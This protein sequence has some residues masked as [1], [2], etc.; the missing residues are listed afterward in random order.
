MNT[1][2][3]PAA[4]ALHGSPRAVTP[5]A[6]SGAAPVTTKMPCLACDGEGEAEYMGLCE[7]RYHVRPCHVCDGTGLVEPYCLGCEGPLDASGMCRDCDYPS[8]WELAEQAATDS[9]RRV[10]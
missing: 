8:G 2:P 1:R 5:G 4:T 3:H 9:Y 6:V 7:D 10:G